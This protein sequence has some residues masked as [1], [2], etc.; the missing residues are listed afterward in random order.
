KVLVIKRDKI[1]D[2][3]LTTPLLAQLK[4][5]LP[6]VETH[7]LA[8]DYNA[9]VVAGNPHLDRV[10]VYRRVRNAGR[11]NLGAAWQWLWQ[12]LAL[13]RERYDWVIVANGDESPRAIRRGLS[14]RG[15][16]TVACCADASKYPGLSDPLPPD[17]ASHEI[18][19]LLALLLPLGISVLEK[20]KTPF[21]HYS[22]PSASAAFARAWLAER[23]LAPGK[24]VVLG[25]GARRPQKQPSTA[26]VLAWSAHLKQRW[27][28]DTVFIWTPGKPDDPL[29]PG[30]DDAARPVLQA[31]APQIHA[32]HEPTIL[33]ALGLIWSARTNIFPDSG[34]MQ[35]AAASPGGVL[36]LFAESDESPSPAQWAP[37]GPRADYLEA[38]KSVSELPEALVYERL[39][40]LLA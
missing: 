32:L 38:E 37:R 18:E 1:G 25:L 4:A 11:V 39:A 8:N 23:G 13:R 6:Q 14:V 36:G 21:P 15:A 28:L 26:Q 10:W 5:G 7:L 19:R 24:Y 3:L 20:S 17:T 40:K 9:W 30:D 22:L 2:L 12:S 35:F 29:Y 16:R 31:R 33:R 27:D 34:L